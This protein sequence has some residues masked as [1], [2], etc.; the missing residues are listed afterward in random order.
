MALFDGAQLMRIER[1]VEGLREDLKLK[2]QLDRIESLL[3]TIADGLTGMTSAEADAVAGKL[4]Q[5]SS[6]LDSITKT[7]SPQ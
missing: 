2:E 5:V 6:K 1:K 4:N 3:K 7:P